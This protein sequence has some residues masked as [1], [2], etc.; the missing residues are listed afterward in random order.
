[1]KKAEIA[2]LAEYL[3]KESVISLVN[4]TNYT[5][6]TQVFRERRT[7]PCRRII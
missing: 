7:N 1:M 2:S 3:R 6:S 4:K 5:L